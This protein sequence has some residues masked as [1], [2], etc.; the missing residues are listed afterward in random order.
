MKNLTKL[1]L[2]L[3][4]SIA[5]CSGNTDYTPKRTGYFRIDF[6]ERKYST[7]KSECPFVFDYP[8][9]S[10]IDSVPGHPYWLNIVFPRFRCNVYLSYITIDTNLAALVE[11]CRKFVVEHEVKAT[12]INEQ[13]VINAKDK[14]YGVIYDIEGNAASN[15]QFY[16][17]DSTHSFVRGALYFYAVPNKDSLQPVANFI[18]EDMNHLIQTFRWKNKPYSP[19]PLLSHEK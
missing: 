12:A 2:L 13:Q 16:L 18:K 17:T 6:P 4:V 3:A 14:I 8:A 19:T 15:M 5:G 9:Y 11:E 7:Y 10:V 1:G